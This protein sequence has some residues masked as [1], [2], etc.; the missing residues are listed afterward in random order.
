MR[1]TRTMMQVVRWSCGCG[2]VVLSSGVAAA[3]DSAAQRPGTQITVIGCVQRP[4]SGGSLGGTPT[5]SAATPNTADDRANNPLPD[6]GYI[7]AGA[8]LV[9]NVSEGANREREDVSAA[10]VDETSQARDERPQLLTYALIGDEAALAQHV[11]RTVEIAGVVAPPVEPRRPV[12]SPD[13][14]RSPDPAPDPVGKAFQTGVRQLRVTSL[15]T[16]ASSCRQPAP[17]R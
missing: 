12:A 9:A 16:V 11:G 6:P 14:V 4:H 1:L 7:V 10:G 15:R 2:L 3:Q 8:R 17:S 5:G 13:P